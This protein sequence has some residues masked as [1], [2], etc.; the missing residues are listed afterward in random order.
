MQYLF[1]SC[2]PHNLIHV[3]IIIIVVVVVQ[4]NKCDSPYFS[5]S[6]DSSALLCSTV[7]IRKILKTATRIL[8]YPET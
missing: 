1:S 6:F 7:I 5:L 4:N 3:I 8:A 2:E